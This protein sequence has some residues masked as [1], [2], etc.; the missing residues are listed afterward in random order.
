MIA[1]LYRWKLRD[2]RE[3]EFRAAWREVTHSIRAAHGTLGSRL[4]KAKDG[5]W[6]AYAQWPSVEHRERA[7]LGPSAN[8]TAS[9][10]MRSCIEQSYDETQLEMTDDLLE[11]PSL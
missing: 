8:P 11:H 10:R 5:T 6:V 1:I 7:R 2:G 4:H 3:E 9:A